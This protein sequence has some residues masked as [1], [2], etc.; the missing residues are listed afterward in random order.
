MRV[1][2][3]VLVMVVVSS[4]ARENAFCQP[5][6]TAS[7]D[8]SSIDYFIRDS[9]IYLLA[10]AATS[11]GMKIT[12]NLF[13]DRPLD[14]GSV[15]DQQEAVGA[16][17]LITLLAAPWADHHLNPEKPRLPKDYANKLSSGFAS[18]ASTA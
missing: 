14:F 6:S 10:G 17:T 16:V 1:K 4:L 13:R 9:F 3:F 2:N 8:T 7:N 15:I 12:F 5:L 11:K 18:L